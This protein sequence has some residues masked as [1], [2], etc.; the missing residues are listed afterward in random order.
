MRKIKII[1]PYIPFLILIIWA[2]MQSNEMKNTRKDIKQISYGISELRKQQETSLGAL[3]RHNE[4]LMNEILRIEQEAQNTALQPIEFTTELQNYLIQ[5]CEKYGVP[6]NIMMAIIEHESR[7]I[8]KPAKED[9]NG[10]M[11]IGYTQINYP[12]WKRLKE[13]YGIDVTTHTGNIEGGVIILS[14]LLEIFPLEKAIVGYECGI[15]KV[16]RLKSTDFSR[17]ILQRAE[18]Y[19]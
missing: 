16:N 6:Y 17:W 10:L 5:T 1:L 19:S 13:H 12:H 4:D 15:S 2:I 8:W 7:F 14:E 18:Y 11:S 3:N 9:T